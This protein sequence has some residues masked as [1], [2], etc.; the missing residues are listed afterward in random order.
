MI[1]AMMTLMLFSLQG[2][3]KPLLNFYAL[4]QSGSLV[5]LIHYQQRDHTHFVQ[6]TD[7]TLFDITKYNTKYKI[8]EEHLVDAQLSPTGERWDNTRF[9]RAFWK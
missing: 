1:L 9:I 7:R 6:E 3:N 5:H 2:S 8:T 4:K